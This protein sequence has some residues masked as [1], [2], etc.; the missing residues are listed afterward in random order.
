MISEHLL[1]YEI[2]NPFGDTKL[3]NHYTYFAEDNWNVL[4]C[5]Y[6][7][8]IPFCSSAYSMLANTMEQF[9]KGIYV[10]LHKIKP[11]MPTLTDY[12]MND[13]CFNRFVQLINKEIPVSSSKEGYFKILDNASRIYKGYTDSKYRNY[14][15]YEDFARDFRRYEVQR[16]RLYSALNNE[17]R[18]FEFV[19]DKEPVIEEDDDLN[20]YR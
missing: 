5:F 20:Y 14:Y 12:E 7:K 15:E 6:E 16:E 17:R 10:E 13:H 9:Y 8:K 1:D 3:N 2:K 11:N 19:H 18:K 4:K